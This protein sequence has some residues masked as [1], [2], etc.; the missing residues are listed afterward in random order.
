M[1]VCQGPAAPRQQMRAVMTAAAVVLLAGVLHQTA[2]TIFRGLFRLASCPLDLDVGVAPA[3]API[4]AAGRSVLR[5]RR[6]LVVGGTRGIGRGI[7]LTL[8]SSGASV[9]IVGRSNGDA[10][11]R[12]MAERA[13]AVA[14]APAAS[15]AAAFSSHAAD[16]S[17]VG[18]C[19][20]LVAELAGGEAYDYV[21]FTVGVWPNFSDPFTAD[22]VERVV[23][24]DLLA[25]HVLLKGLVG[26][27]LLQPSAR[28][29]N[30]LASTQ[31]FP[32]IDA[33]WVQ[34]RL[35]ASYGDGAA[36]PGELFS[37]LVPV[38]AAADAYLQQAASQLP[39]VT[40]VGM[41]PGACGSS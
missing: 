12:A 23:A 11:V 30:T 22:G 21:F 9:S 36:P 8:A 1:W 16:L 5:G 32:L 33:D 41:F 15:D 13:A 28:V 34:G 18:G 6:A 10:V 27:S 26:R 2:P 29:M 17:T 25:R 24:L 35:R 39:S 3:L 19:A 20:A 40:F 14:P 38:S 4:G 7:A 31:R 37:A